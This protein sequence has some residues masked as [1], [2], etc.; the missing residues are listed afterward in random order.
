[1][2]SVNGKTA[3]VTGADPVNSYTTLKFKVCTDLIFLGINLCFVQALL[4]KG[5]NVPIADRVFSKWCSSS[6]T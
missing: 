1:M 5:C 2:I 3:I 4:V 6:A